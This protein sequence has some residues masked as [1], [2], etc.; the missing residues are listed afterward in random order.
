MSGEIDF[1]EVYR[2]YQPKILHYISRLINP[3]EAEDI[4]QEVFEKISH[5]LKGFKGESKLSTWIFRI[6]T[7]TALDKVKTPSRSRSRA[8]T[9]LDESSEVGDKN[10]WTG[11]DKLPVDQELIRKEMSDCVREFVDKLPPDQRTVM[12][13]SELGG[14][15]NKEIADILQV[16]LETVKIRLHRA[17][18]GLK[19]LLEDGCSFYHDE[20][21]TLACDRKNSLLKLKKSD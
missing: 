19:K 10:V 12:L 9:S 4:T 16:S 1:K 20:Q 18:T 11:Q 7:N 15:K 21:S 6:A 13:L 8:V 3:Q 5:G 14:F 2:E 17:R